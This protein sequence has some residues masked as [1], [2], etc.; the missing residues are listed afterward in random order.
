MSETPIVVVG[1]G[2]NGLTAAALLAKAGRKVVV[3]EARD[4]AG[5]LAA[6]ETFGDGH[7]VPGLLHDTSGVRDRVVRAL[8]LARHGLERRADPLTVVAGGVRICGARVEGEVSATDVE[9]FGEYHA[10]LG[11]VGGTLRGLLDA[12]VPDPKGSLW[13]LL[14]AGW[15]VRRLGARDMVELMR[16]APTCVADWTRDLFDS[17]QLQ[18]AVAAPALEGNYFGPWSAG[19]ALTLLLRE[20]VAGGE[21]VGGPAA[22]TDALLAAAKAQGVDVRL[23][24]PVERIQVDKRA[25]CGVVVGGETIATTRVLATCDPKLTFLKLVGRRAIP[26]DLAMAM[27]NI[28]ARG[29]TAKMHLALSGPLQTASGQSFDVLRTGATLD[30]LERAFDAIKYGGF[31]ERPSLE[32]RQPSPNVASVLVHFA[33]HDLKGGW[34]DAQREALGDAAVREL[35]RHCPNVTD[36]VTAREVLTPADLEARYGLTGGHI[37]HGEHAPDQLLFL[38][39]TIDCARNRT[40]VG[41]LWLG[42]SG[43]HPGGGITCA[44]GMLAAEALLAG[45]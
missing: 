5:G 40:P 17:E 38:R 34:T 11:R 19:S 26:A 32:V 7:E 43:S 41:G 21:V 28:R 31:S 14:R 39:P 44:P 10:F 27:R 33:P 42:G 35:A 4:R 22:L 16:V 1:A 6:R 25:V 9:R 13:A 2:H 24:A 30:E 36:L 12:P 3:V 8:D 29:T 23:G 18:A 37:H 45:A 20:C 15:S